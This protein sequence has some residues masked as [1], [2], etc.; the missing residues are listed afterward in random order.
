MRDPSKLRRR[1]ACLA[2]LA[3]LAGC[4]SGTLQGKVYTGKP[5]TPVEGATVLVLDG[6]RELGRF[7]TEA[8][9]AFS[10]ALRC[11]SER[12]QVAIY[13]PGAQV[14]AVVDAVRVIGG[15][16]VVRN[17]QVNGRQ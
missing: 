9:G 10:L 17:Y 11:R 8:D 7:T 12:Y 5:L 14:P 2:P 1:A 15:G 13:E 3:L 6:E 16:D 4:C